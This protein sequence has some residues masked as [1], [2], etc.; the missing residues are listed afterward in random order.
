MTLKSPKRGQP[1]REREKAK[2]WIQLR[3]TMSRKNAYVRAAKPKT[4]SNWIF[5]VLD[6]ASGYEPEPREHD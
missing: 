6:K 2:G 1:R 5:K 4:L 3:V